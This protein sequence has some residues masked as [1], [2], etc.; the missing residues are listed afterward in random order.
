LGRILKNNAKRRDDADGALS[1]AQALF[2]D[3]ADEEE[4][5]AK[6]QNRSARPDYLN[7]LA[8]AS[9]ERGW[10]LVTMG[11]NREAEQT[12]RDSVTRLDKLA[13]DSR[14]LPDFRENLGK[15]QCDLAYL[16]KATGRVAEAEAIYWKA[17]DVY[18]KLAQAFPHV[19]RYHGN[20]GSTQDALVVLLHQKG[21]L[22]RA[23][24]LA[25]TA[26]RHQHV[27]LDAN[28][29]EWNFRLSLQQ[30][31]REF[32]HVLV[33]LGEHS[34]AAEASNE[35]ADIIPGCPVGGTE[36][37]KLFALIVGLVEKDSR[38]STQERAALVA[39]YVARAKELRSRV[40]RG[41]PSS[42]Y[43]E[44]EV[45]WYLATYPD[46]RFRDP[47]HAA[48]LAER[49]I[50]RNPKSGDYWNTLGVARY[51]QGDWKAAI[52]ALEKSDKLNGGR[53]PIDALF[54]SMAHWQLGQPAEARKWFDR[55]TDVLK[56]PGQETEE[57]RRF[58]AEA[59][60]LLHFGSLVAG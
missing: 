5:E 30:L 26:I 22:Q 17:L 56:K 54:L 39:R 32:V 50:S 15:A 4:S 42:D 37:M 2:R 19:A 46:A 59:A 8:A 38:L 1:H 51:R 35:V 57:V 14:L 12:L 27:A 28:P 24:D 49:A 53:Q 20:L 10:V 33:D 3:L 48:A 41:C 55:A 9:A 58:R 60:M 34:R 16:L 11:R 31:N 13:A 44:N 18:D 36:A 6:K 43:F 47:S 7:L 25:E 45:A 23:R 29:G 21:E 52:T 40:I